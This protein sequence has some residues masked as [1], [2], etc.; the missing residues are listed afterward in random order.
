MYFLE[1]L[2]KPNIFTRIFLGFFKNYIAI[3]FAQFN[4]D[5]SFTEL[6]CK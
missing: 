1:Q 5:R 2:R 4:L 3:L 6:A